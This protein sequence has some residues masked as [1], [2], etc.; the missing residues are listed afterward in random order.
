MLRTLGILFFLSFLSQSISAQASAK[1]GISLLYEKTEGHLEAIQFFDPEDGKMVSAF[2]IRENN[3]FN[4]LDFPIAGRNA[5]GQDQYRLDL[6]P[7]TKGYTQLVSKHNQ[8]RISEYSTAKRADSNILYRK[9]G[10]RFIIIAYN[11]MVRGEDQRIIGERSRLLVLNRRGEVMRQIENNKY[12]IRNAI[13]SNDGK[14]LAFIFGHGKVQSGV[15]AMNGACLYKIDQDKALY[16]EESGS[17][18]H[19][20]ATL[21][22]ESGHMLISAWV[23]DSKSNTQYLMRFFD[24]EKRVYYSHS[25]DRKDR[26]EMA[27]VHDYGIEFKDEKG[28]S[29]FML[30]ADFEKEVF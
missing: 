5:E 17:D 8:L 14:Y 19:Y 29:R 1:T 20:H 26:E 22:T 3:P 9:V 16:C 12:I 30:F 28:E 7:G 27:R 21:E 25:F 23:P 24:M 2:N 18:V 13:L 15:Q 6:T 4:G 10:D 11:L